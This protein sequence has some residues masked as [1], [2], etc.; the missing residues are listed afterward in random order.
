[1]H[2][3]TKPNEP[4]NTAIEKLNLNITAYR[5]L[6]ILRLLVENTA[7][8][9]IELNDKLIK[10]PYINRGFNGETITKYMNTLR[11]LNCKIPKANIQQN[12]QYQLMEAP[13]PFPTSDKEIEVLR[14]L[15]TILTL[16]PNDEYYQDFQKLL[17]KICWSIADK[18]KSQALQQLNFKEP[19]KQL[20]E[21]RKKLAY[22]RQI[23]KDGQAIEISYTYQNNTTVTLIVEPKQ[24]IQSNQTFF[25]IATDRK[26]Y[27]K[28]KL[29]INNISNLKQLPFKTRAISKTVNVTFELTGRLAQNYRLY[30]GEFYKQQTDTK[31]VIKATVYD[32]ESLINRLLK[33][34]PRCKVLSPEYIQQELLDRVDAIINN[35]ST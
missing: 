1:M 3:T 18:E 4:P 35:L 28:V 15:H 13:F 10:N 25:L 14:K 21:K 23:C 29:N 5:V 8:S 24:V 7:L 22:Y 30:P 26:A 33:Y 12:Y 9:F 19:D 31:A 11:H 20:T 6:Y 2:T 16:E 27:Q 34:G 32:T 17:Q